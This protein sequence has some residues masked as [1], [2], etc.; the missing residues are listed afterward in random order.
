MEYKGKEIE[1]ITEPQI[2]N[3]PQRMLVWDD[4]G[5]KPN[6]KEALVQAI[7]V[8]KHSDCKV[9]CE[10]DSSLIRFGHCAKIPRLLATNFELSKWLAQGNGEV[11]T[12][13]INDGHHRE[14]VTSEWHYF[15][16][17]EAEEVSYGFNGARCKGV[18]RWDDPHWHEPT[19]EYLG[20]E[21]SK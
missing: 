13:M 3:P 10:N 6:V 12:L 1:E 15:S 5:G 8:S 11:L 21:S 7:V 16:G 9:I 2:F 20:I 19:K 14:A 18:R 17:T 4:E